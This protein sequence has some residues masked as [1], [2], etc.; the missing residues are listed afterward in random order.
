M[1]TLVVVLTV[2]KIT[3]TFRDELADVDAPRRTVCADA[4]VSCAEE[5]VVEV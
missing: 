1:C 2:H 5:V 3:D 4:I